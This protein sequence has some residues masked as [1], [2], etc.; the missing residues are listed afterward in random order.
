[1]TA[2]PTALEAHE[3][4]GGHAATHQSVLARSV[5]ASYTRPTPIEIPILGGTIGV[6]TFVLPVVP[7]APSPRPAPRLALRPPAPPRAPSPSRP[8]IQV[9]HDLSANTVT[10]RSSGRTEQAVPGGTMVQEDAWRIDLTKAPPYRQVI[11]YASVRTLRR[12][13]Q[14]ELRVTWRVRTDSA[15]PRAT[16]E[17][18]ERPI[19]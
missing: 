6:S 18:L 13:G 19:P 16:V 3:R 17:W 1:M 14:P 7:A 2:V 12:P 5:I 15:G 11:D 4:V 9:V 10:Y 8:T